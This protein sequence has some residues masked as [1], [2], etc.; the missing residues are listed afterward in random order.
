[1][2]N[3]LLYFYCSRLNKSIYLFKIVIFK[4]EL[5]GITNGEALKSGEV[6]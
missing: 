2:K 1:M 4:E 3:L 6:A 5:Q